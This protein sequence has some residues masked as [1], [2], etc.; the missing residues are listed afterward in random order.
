MK[1]AVIGSPIAHSL[2]P[3]LHRAAY[4]E[5]GL[6]WEYDRREVTAAEVRD[7]IEGLDRT[8]R[9][10]SVTMPC[11]RAIVPLGEPDPVVA[12]L[13]V[14]NT[15]IFDGQPGDR[16]ATRVHNTDVTG[17]QLVL[18]ALDPAAR[19]VVYGN[20]ATARSCV[21]ALAGLGVG[22]V[23]VRARDAAKTVGLAADGAAW[24]IAVAPAD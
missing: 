23:A 18:G 4:A 20:G 6:D 22:R 21:Y 11:K 1:C 7:F 9:G 14:G 3:V 5:L 10:L 17:I 24:G 16:A 13:G 15:L 19:I 8:W 12:A 2:S